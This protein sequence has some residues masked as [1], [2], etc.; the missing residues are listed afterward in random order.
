MSMT[1]IAKVLLVLPTFHMAAVQA[2]DIAP[3]TERNRFI[4]DAS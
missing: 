2:T 1:H 3:D 4:I